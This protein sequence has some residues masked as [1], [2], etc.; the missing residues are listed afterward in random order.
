MILLLK[1]EKNFEGANNIDWG[2]TE[3]N[4]LIGL[5]AGFAGGAVGHW[6]ANSSMLVNNI[7]SPVLRSA[8]VS[9]IASGAGHIAGG[10]TAGLI[11][12]QNLGDAFRNSFKGIGSSMGIGLTVEVT[13]TIGVSY[14]NKIS[15]WTGEL[16][17]KTT[18][19]K[20]NNSYNF[21]P[22]P[23]WR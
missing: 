17:L 20:N 8:V 22:D 19:S 2:H 13:P 16:L 23:Q 9:P 4:S 12:R 3:K 1:Q 18:P 21:T 7:N 14:A 6:A 5:G 11:Y 15:P 10:T